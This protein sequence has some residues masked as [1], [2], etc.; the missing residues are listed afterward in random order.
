METAVNA[1]MTLVTHVEKVLQGVGGKSEISEHQAM[2]VHVLLK[3]PDNE[4]TRTKVLQKLFGDVDAYVLN[5]VIETLVE[6]NAVTAQT[7]GGQ[8]F[9]KLTPA[10]LK[11]LAEWKRRDK[12]S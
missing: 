10:Y 12:K 2:V 9:Y 3:A 7:R 11:Q 8:I 4:L 5:R 6:A 1:C